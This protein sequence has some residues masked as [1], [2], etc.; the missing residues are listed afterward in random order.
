MAL[1]QRPSGTFVS[2][3]FV[4]PDTVLESQFV[5][6][7][8][9]QRTK[10]KNTNCAKRSTRMSRNPDFHS[11]WRVP[12]SLRF[13]HGKRH[14]LPDLH[15]RV[16]KRDGGALEWEQSGECRIGLP[17]FYETSL[18]HH[19]ISPKLWGDQSSAFVSL[20][21]YIA[22]CFNAPRNQL[23]TSSKWRFDFL[24]GHHLTN[25]RITPVRTSTNIFKKKSF[26]KPSL[27]S[28]LRSKNKNAQNVRSDEQWFWHSPHLCVQLMQQLR[29]KGPWHRRAVVGPDPQAEINH[30]I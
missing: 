29:H 28:F 22:C 11:P 30:Q 19:D 9:H 26:G 4:R 20:M 25:K 10:Q 12:S 3:Q 13:L 14:F 27:V 1:H 7:A 23:Q 18:C 2:C 16:R 6:P 24:I 8:L 17:S 15:F 5:N 21:I